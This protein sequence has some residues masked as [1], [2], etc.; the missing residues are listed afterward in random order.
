[1]KRMNTKR[2]RI[3]S[4]VATV[5]TAAAVTSMA[6]ATSAFASEQL[7]CSLKSMS[8]K[9]DSQVL[10]SKTVTLASTNPKAEIDL[11][12]GTFSAKADL[13]QSPNLDIFYIDITD[14]S[15]AREAGLQTTSAALRAGELSSTLKIGADGSWVYAECSIKN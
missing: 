6:L 15:T 12:Q 13:D 14:S 5:T 10:Q 3:T 7:E 1:M 11:S 9:G 2:S 4:I 8:P